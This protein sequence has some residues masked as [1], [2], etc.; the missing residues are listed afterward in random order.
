MS[1]AFSKV[2]EVAQDAGIVL[3]CSSAIM[4]LNA[5]AEDIART[6]I[7]VLLQGDSGTGKE[8]YARYIHRRS[9]RHGR[10]LTKL[11]CASFDF[12]HLLASFG[13]LASNE[14]ATEPGREAGTLCLDGLDELSTEG[15]RL[16]LSSL[17]AQE[18]DAGGAPKARLISTATRNLHKDVA[19][20]SFRR[21]LY[22]RI[23]GACLRLPQ[24]KE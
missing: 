1:V 21:E 3:G 5:A 8:I 23:A 15:Q 19:S 24:L 9:L 20:G 16:L 22:F 13:G 17:Q 2:P 12:A 18:S 10:P 7:P 14:A 11:N 4:S 6:D